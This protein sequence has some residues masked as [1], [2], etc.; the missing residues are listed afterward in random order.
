MEKS[1]FNFALGAD[2]IAFWGLIFAGLSVVIAAIGVL[3]QFVFGR[4]EPIAR[5]PVLRELANAKAERQSQGVGRAVIAGTLAD[6][7][8]HHRGRVPPPKDMPDHPTSSDGTKRSLGDAVTDV[9][10]SLPD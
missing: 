7:F 2:E 1:L 3:F 8:L 5:D 4:R 6:H 10:D 9:L